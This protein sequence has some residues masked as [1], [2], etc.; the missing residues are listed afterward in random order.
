[1][2]CMLVFFASTWA[3]NSTGQRWAVVELSTIYMRA[4]ADYESALETQ[5]LMGT[6]VEI[7]EEKGYWRKIVS[8]QPYTAWCT[9]KGLVEMDAKDIEEYKTA[10]KCM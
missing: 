4:D 9:E 1:M 3:Q 8:P 2:V 5:E 7:V 6:V 10:A